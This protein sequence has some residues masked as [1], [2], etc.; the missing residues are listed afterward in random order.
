MDESLK[1]YDEQVKHKAPAE[2]FVARRRSWRA[3]RARRAE[4]NRRG[5]QGVQIL[6]SAAQRKLRYSE[7]PYYPRPVNEALG[8]FALQYARQQD[9]GG[10]ERVSRPANATGSAGQRSIGERA[11]GDRKTR[12]ETD[13][14]RSS[15]NLCKLISILGGGPAGASAAISALMRGVNALQLI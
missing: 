5:H 14:R 3:H 7:P 2:L 8:E 15:V 1:A 10:A 11:R 6:A 12:D 4:E 13:R 9:R